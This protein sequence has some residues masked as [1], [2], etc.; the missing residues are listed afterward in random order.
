MSVWLSFLICDTYLSH[1]RIGILDGHDEEQMPIQIVCVCVCVCMCVCV[2]VC[3]YV[4]V[5]VCVCV[6][7]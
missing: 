1:V 2:C 6:H 5:C 7:W 4:C 3:V